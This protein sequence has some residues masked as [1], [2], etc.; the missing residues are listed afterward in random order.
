MQK[1]QN[2][3]QSDV[4]VFED[5]YVDSL[6]QRIA[7]V[8]DAV[9]DLENELKKRGLYKC[10]HPVSENEAVEVGA[11]DEVITICHE[12]GAEV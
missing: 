9:F 12:C 8:K 3:T 6:N 5:E 11:T 1:L 4:E 2:A 10:F 7:F